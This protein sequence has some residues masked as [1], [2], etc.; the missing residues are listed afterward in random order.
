VPLFARNKLMEVQGF[1]LRMV[2]NNC[3]ELKALAE[4]PRLDTRVNLTLV[5]LVIPLEGGRPQVRRAFFALT[6]EF[7]GT[8]V[9]LVV[10]GPV[11]TEDALLGFRSEDDMVFVRATSRHL[12][13]MGGGFY[14]FGMQLEEVVP[15]GDYSELQSLRF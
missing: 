9:G 7:S 4:G 15:A 8:G 14:Q 5:A 1:V 12:S 10:E 13:P 11:T 3:P 2:N 6:K